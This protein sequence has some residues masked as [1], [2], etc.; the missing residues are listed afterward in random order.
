MTTDWFS[1]VITVAA[2]ILVVAL[3]VTVTYAIFFDTEEP[4]PMVLYSDRNL[5]VRAVCTSDSGVIVTTR[6]NARIAGD[7]VSTVR[8]TPGEVAVYCVE[9]GQ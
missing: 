7:A 6:F 5:E 8:M 9:G 3:A 2:I 4:D 1:I